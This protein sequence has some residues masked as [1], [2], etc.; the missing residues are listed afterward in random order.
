MGEQMRTNR[1][2]VRAISVV[3]LAA[4]LAACG[5]DRQASPSTDPPVAT[6]AAEAAASTGAT[7]AQP[8][9]TPSTEPE[10]TTTDSATPD[11][12]HFGTLAWPCG[13]AETPNTDDGTTPGVTS[14]TVKI[15]AGDDAG[16]ANSPGLNQ[17]T[18]Q[19]V[20][21]FAQACNELGGIHGRQIVVNYYDAA[22]TSIAS[23]IQGAC[24]GGNFFLV[25]EGWSFDSAQEEIR[26][27]C[28]LPAVPAYTVSGEF[29]MAPD[30][31]TGIPNPADEV[32]SGTFALTAQ[33]FPDDVHA[34]ATLGGNI[35]ATQETIEKVRAAAP[36][37]GWTFAGPPFEYDV[38]GE[39]ADWTPIVKEVQASGA[40]MIYW[41]GNCLPLLQ[42]FTQ[43]AHQNGLDVP[44]VS[45]PTLYS[46][47]CKQANS[48]GTL[49]NLYIRFPYTPFEEAATNPATAEYIR[50]IEGSGGKTSLLGME[51]A[52]SFLLWAQAAAGCGPEL[53]RQCVLDGLAGVHSWTAGGLHVET[54]PGGNHAP[55]CLLLLRLVDQTYERVLPEQAGTFEC[56]PS[57]VTPVS[58]TSVLERLELDDAR[59]Y[60]PDN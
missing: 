32:S 38:F 57:W 34:V 43:T 17:E 44:I 40:R 8:T 56:D 23:A 41:L 52:S 49:N 46:E 27:S 59:K 55:A 60:H 21:A 11:A 54:D 25:G 15:A 48:D 14:D 5:S 24:D 39:I 50:L 29:A 20:N 7:G 33:L 4:L 2:L 47:P 3:G 22:V 35:A 16:F 6:T 53:T 18:T 28:S 36:E 58:N 37:F 30:V 42:R 9:E 19:A 51:G 12:A 1:R 26:R 31:Y 13:P 10:S 45:E